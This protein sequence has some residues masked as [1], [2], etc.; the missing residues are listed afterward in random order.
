MLKSLVREIFRSKRGLGASLGD[1]ATQPYYDFDGLARQI[2]AKA[3]Y[4]G[5]NGFIDY[6]ALVH[7]ETMAVCNAACVF[8]PYPGLER[9]GTKMPDALI[10]KIID[11]LSAMPRNLPFQFAPYKVS[12]PFIEPRLFDIIGLACA[13]LPAAQVSLITNG[14]ALTER[15]IEQLKKVK[16]VA[17]LNVSLNFDNAEEYEEVMKLPFERTLQRL[18]ALHKARAGGGL[19]FVIRMT[20]VSCDRSSDAAFLQWVRQRYPGFEAAILP[21]NDWIGEVVTE[22]ALTQVPD[23]PCHRWFDLSITATG[24]VAM[25]CM[26][27]EAKYPKGDASRQNVLEIYNQPWLRAL[28]RDL[29]SRKRAGSPCDRC[30]YLSY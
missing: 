15:K 3:H 12:D 22:N 23:A 29:I 20:R 27:G 8:C 17:Y 21:R 13:K 24:V 25:C 5:Q 14:A 7:I 1:W 16:A 2:S 11:D 10:E 26:D 6:P 30:T 18:D 9:K 19:D 4:L 28:R